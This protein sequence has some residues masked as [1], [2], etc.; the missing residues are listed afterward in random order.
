ME[1]VLD[2]FGENVRAARVAR[3]WTQEDLAHRSGLA[4]V[5]V[6]RIERGKREIRLTTFVRDGRGLVAAVVPRDRLLAAGRAGDV[7]GP[8]IEGSASA[9]RVALL[10]V[11]YREAWKLLPEPS[12]E[13]LMEELEHQPGEI[14]FVLLMAT[15][16]LETQD[17]ALLRAMDKPDA[18][19]LLAVVLGC[20]D[21]AR[22]EALLHAWPPDADSGL[23]PRGGDEWEAR[24]A[25]VEAAMQTYEGAGFTRSHSEQDIRAQRLIAEASGPG[26]RLPIRSAAFAGAPA[27]A[28]NLIARCSPEALPGRSRARSAS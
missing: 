9:E 18:L 1:G 17:W 22:Y 24:W 3:G 10:A 15:D 25:E 13:A 11:I 12:R 7:G 20:Y 6:S 8:V 5:Q 27:P 2:R 19:P 28:K 26:A 4:V 23:V 21:P 14:S 16:L